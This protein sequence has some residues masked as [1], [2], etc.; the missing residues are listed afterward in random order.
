MWVSKLQYKDE[1]SDR[2]RVEG[3]TNEGKV[4]GSVPSRRAAREFYT[5]NTTTN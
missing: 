2:W 1:V 3:A 5:E 4:G